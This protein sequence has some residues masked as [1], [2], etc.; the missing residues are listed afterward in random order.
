MAL[1]PKSSLHAVR[2]R[3]AYSILLTDEEILPI[4]LKCRLLLDNLTCA[5]FGSRI[6]CAF[7]KQPA[8][9]KPNK[10]IKRPS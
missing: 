2:L 3:M 10:Q 6:F 5:D 4:K 7:K 9:Y 8:L 1:M